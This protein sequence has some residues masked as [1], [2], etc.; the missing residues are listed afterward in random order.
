MMNRL[1]FVF[2]LI[3]CSL[4]ELP[5]R[6][7]LMAIAL[8][9][10]WGCPALPATE[11][12]VT[13]RKKVSEGL[14]H[15]SSGRFSEAVQAFEQ[16]VEKS[17][18]NSADS[19]VVLFDQACALRAA[20]EIDKA[21]EIFLQVA[22]GD[23]KQ[24]ASESHYNLA[25]IA[26]EEGRQTLGQDPLAA[27]AEQ[28]QKATERLQA[29]ISHYRDSLRS[30]A[31]NEDAR[32]NMEL[33]RLYIKN[34][35]ES[36]R[37]RDLQQL[38]DKQDLFQF[39]VHLDE[40]QSQVRERTRE[41]EGR[42]PRVSRLERAK[43]SESQR[44]LLA[45][46]AP[47]NSKIEAAL[48]PESETAANQNG[49]AVQQPQLSAEQQDTIRQLK[50]MISEITGR[51]EQSIAA[52]AESIQAGKMADA[53]KIQQSTRDRFYET[54]A[55][56]APFQLI[57]QRAI[58]DQ[59]SLL[60]HGKQPGDAIPQKRSSDP[61]TDYD[62]LAWRQDWI[63]KL[64]HALSPKA[65]AMLQTIP[66]EKKAGQVQLDQ[67]LTTDSESIESAEPSIP[68]QP[69]APA[70]DATVTDVTVPDVSDSGRKS[71]DNNLPQE[72]EKS[73]EE[74]TEALR[75]ALEKA[76]ESSPMIV[77]HSK[78]AQQNLR[79][80][81]FATAEPEQREVLR[82][83]KEIA[84]LLPKQPPQN[85]PDQNQLPDQNQQDKNQQDKNQQDQDNKQKQDPNQQSK[86]SGEQQDSQSPD[87]QHS[88]QQKS[89]QGKSP[90]QPPKPDEQS[91]PPNQ[92]SK[93]EEEKDSQKSKAEKD[94]QK[95]DQQKQEDAEANESR[96]DPKPASATQA[97]KEAAKEMAQQKAAEERA[98]VILRRIRER[99][100]KYR[101]LLEQLR[102]LQNQRTPVDKDW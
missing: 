70:D 4:V 45:D 13:A 22:I 24:L 65:A 30:D 102:E 5:R 15:Y 88:D 47:L 79:Q 60:D 91:Q 23:N 81:E 67:E 92:P 26:V 54:Y 41:F 19:T 96:S 59:Q 37:E 14:E 40:Q 95:S 75:R 72:K 86:D 34:L 98:Q 11:P 57:L 20:G 44:K 16:A 77:E 66:P 35:Q 51:A 93:K 89:D 9:S 25:A 64:S 1:S 29:A 83:L 100:A 2:S 68:D 58:D 85:Q 76:I 48:Q 53:S 36:W 7:L 55:V 42:G 46:I 90:D 49:A 17:P 3:A 73:V 6:C 80:R 38:R 27:E 21:R 99:E 12:E 87:Q 43:L 94:K 31:R 18:A 32:H 61:G 63:S 28:R 39:L 56:M 97:E 101:G 74:T 84:D 69:Q 50:Q 71:V 8:L 52:A 10:F 82:L 78:L 62:A 33:V